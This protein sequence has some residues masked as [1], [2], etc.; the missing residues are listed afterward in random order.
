MVKQS[1]FMLVFFAIALLAI[2]FASADIALS[3]PSALT[4]SVEQGDSVSFTF[5][6]EN[7]NDIPV[8]VSFANSTTSGITSTLP[9]ALI[10]AN[11]TTSNSLTVTFYTNL[12]STSVGERTIALTANG[13]DSHSSTLS[14][15]INVTKS[16][17]TEICGTAYTSE[18][19]TFDDVDDDLDF[20]WR[21]FDDVELTINSINNNVDKDI[22]FDISILFYQ[23]GKRTSD[24]KIAEDTND[25]VS[26]NF[27]IKGED[28][29][30]VKLNF[31]VAGDAKEGSYD[32][33]VKVKGS[34]GCYAKKVATVNINKDSNS[35]IVKDVTGPV[36]S[37]CGE[38]ID[39]SVDVANIGSSDEDQVKVLLYNRELGVNLYKEILN[40]NEG[41]TAAT[42]F[43]F[44]VPQNALERNYKFTVSTE[45]E[46]DDKNDKYDSESDSEDDFVYALGLSGNCIDP[47]KPTI[48][49]QLDSSAVVG[50]NLVIA[51]T[52]KNNGNISTSAIIAPEDYES[53]AELVSVE[54]ATITAG[55]AESK[56]VYITLKPT[57]AGQKIFNLNVIY[58]GKS[59]DQQVTVSV[60]ANSNWTSSMKEQFG[61]FGAYLI[62]GIAVLVALI[63]LV[64]IIKVLVSLVRKH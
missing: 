51:V 14:F 29:D 18:N 33:Y 27:K 4:A 40:L 49:A 9:T 17:I 55:R 8:L 47:S 13:N 19:I 10:V 44:T 45:F 41:D 59:T 36:S 25:L 23:N 1:R 5:N 63:I 35:V 38:T 58:N 60:E 43:S 57:E 2:S 52:F 16:P 15:N 46:Y 3:N 32:A 50:D 31:Q 30:D 53:W 7:T 39:I 61:D 34:T 6:V 48:S 11:N 62:I 56:T 21:P 26:D 28:N 20:E 37:S 24:S 54:P 42:T 22:K 64:L 12:A